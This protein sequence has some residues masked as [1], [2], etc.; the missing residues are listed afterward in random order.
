MSESQVSK[1][2]QQFIK[3]G[4]LLAREYRDEYGHTRYRYSL[5]DNAL[6]RLEKHKMKKVGRKFVRAKVPQ[7]AR[8]EH[9][10]KN[11]RKTQIE[12]LLGGS[13]VTAVGESSLT[14]VSPTRVLQ[15]HCPEW[16]PVIAE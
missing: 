4:W 2:V 16:C 10:R 14:V 3:D 11:L 5:P 15:V 13:D 9:W 12:D 8:A 6:E 1:W 7:Q